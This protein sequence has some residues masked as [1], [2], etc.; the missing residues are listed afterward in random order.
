MGAVQ[1]SQFSSGLFFSCIRL[2]ALELGT[3][4]H[5]EAG[6]FVY[7][8]FCVLKFETVLVGTDLMQVTVLTLRVKSTSV[9][10]SLYQ[11]V[12]L[13]YKRSP[14]ENSPKVTGCFR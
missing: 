9:Y 11:C 5:S 14:N 4:Y 10:Y 2:S 7:L 3:V 12:F 13:A 1:T 6:Y 8:Y